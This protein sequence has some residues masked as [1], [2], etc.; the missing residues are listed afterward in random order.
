[1]ESKF[2]LEKKAKELLQKSPKESAKIYRRIWDEFPDQCNVWDALFSLK[3]LR[4]AAVEDVKW[5]RSLAE[6]HDDEKVRGLFGWYIYDIYVKKKPNDNI[7]RFENL[8]LSLLDLIPQ[9]N[10]REEPS[11]PCP[12]TLTVFKLVDIHSTNNFNAIK[13]N[14]LLNTLD[15]TYLSNTPSKYESQERGSQE[16]PSDTEKFYASKSKALLKLGR[17]EECKSLCEEAL[18]T[19]AKFHYDNDLWFQMRIAICH[20]RT[21][22]TDDSKTLFEKLLS[23]QKGKDKW[24]FYRDLSELYYEEEDYDNAWK[25]SLT[26][27]LNGNEPQYMIKVY[28][29]QLHI[30]RKLDRLDEGKV[31]AELIAS[32]VCEQKWKVKEDYSRMF[33]YYGI[34][35]NVLGESSKY[36]RRAQTFWKAE[37]YHGLQAI[38]GEVIFV[39]KNN[40]IGQIR[41]KNGQTFNFH[42]KHLTKKQHDL[43]RL[44][45]ATVEFYAIHSAND[46]IFAENINVISLKQPSVINAD[47]EII[48]GKVKNIVDFGIFVCF[49]GKPDGLLHISKL[50]NDLKNNFRDEFQKG[51]DITV[52]IIKATDKGL[53][54]SLEQQ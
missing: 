17:Y 28:N 53:E 34:D 12:K 22:N 48:T 31:I 49:Q 2:E 44:K 37:R 29:H 42:R 1:M 26:A 30:L 45:G 47:G 19:L 43:G 52:R 6:K 32:I 14:Q 4:G 9:K 27:A 3:A 46:E 51:D 11:F 25:Y 39:H 10:L 20:E 18:S 40:K 5:A 8:I 50:D 16:Y 38:I 33:A 35:L 41:D 36:F 7:L 23:T 13:V 15:I 24:F 21:G 54:L